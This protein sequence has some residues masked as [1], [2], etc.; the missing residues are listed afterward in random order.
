MFRA[1]PTKGIALVTGASSG[2]GRAVAQELARRGYRVA[3]LARREAELQTLANERPKAFYVY[4]CDVT[5]RARVRAT[6]STIEAEHGS[7][8][9]AF[10]NVGTYFAD[11][12][13][14]V[15]A[16]MIMETFSVNVGGTV[17]CLEPLVEAMCLRKAGQIAVNASV[18]GYGGLPRS[19]A[20]GPSKAAL[21]N[22]AASLKLTLAPFNVR[23]QLVC[24]GFVKTPLTDN[25]KF[26]MPFLISME[27]A[28][29]RICDGFERGGFEIAFPKRM[30]WLL[31]ALNALPYA[32]YFA[33]VG[34]QTG[35]R[36]D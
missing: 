1:S 8:A 12:E 27:T 34:A 16:E 23:V 35:K 15:D 33:I 5:D 4:P 28:A 36:G 7:I 31:K 26:P 10:L 17:N 11:R 24:P 22:M 25:N 30:A 21:I 9:L 32:A 13:A 19:L 14:A 18:A 20:Y 3:I 6:L 2:I 29:T